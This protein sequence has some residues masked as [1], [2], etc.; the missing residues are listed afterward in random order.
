MQE[1]IV[2]APLQFASAEECVRWRREASGTMQHM[3]SGLDDEAKEKIWAEVV[4]AMRQF[5][6][7][8]GFK[9][10]CELLICSAVN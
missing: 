10:P 9:S 2:E 5:E 8:D 6:S 1:Q 7:A 3:L 4:D